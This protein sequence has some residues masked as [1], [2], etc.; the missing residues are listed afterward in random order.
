MGEPV[1]R[2][3]KRLLGYG[4]DELIVC[5]G[6]GAGHQVNLGFIGLLSE[7]VDENL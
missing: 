3:G 2:P 7:G 6:L 5:R 4:N 1:H